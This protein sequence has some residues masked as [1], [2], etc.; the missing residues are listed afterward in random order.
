MTNSFLEIYKKI[1]LIRN[2]K[3]FIK[4]PVDREGCAVTIG[5]LNE[6]TKRFHILIKL[7]LS[8]QSK[9][10]ITHR[11]YLRLVQ[12]YRSL[13]AKTVAE[14]KKIEME[15]LL[16]GINFYNTKAKNLIESA[17]VLNKK[18]DSDVPK[19]L[20]DLLNL[21]GV[22]RKI[23]LL[24]LFCCWGKSKGISVDTHVHRIS[25]RIGWI[26]ENTPDKTSFA[27]EKIVPI[28]EWGTLNKVLVG[29]GQ[30][31]CKAINPLCKNCVVR[32]FCNYF[33]INNKFCK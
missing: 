8:P 28:E 10:E 33:E 27:L 2:T 17:K 13:D 20:S 3:L 16:R 22:G 26:N 21:P 1:K 23:A 24:A 7:L 14:T 31:T 25:N 32:E 11:T 6:K 12:H 29:F 15:S 19:K 30:T 9:D 4:A 5:N 18:F